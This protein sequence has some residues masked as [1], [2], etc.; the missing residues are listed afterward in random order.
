M[1][2]DL[3]GG[4]REGGKAGRAGDEFAREERR[5]GG[6]RFASFR[7]ENGYSGKGL[8]AAVARHPRLGTDC[9]WARGPGIAR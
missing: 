6:R 5:S 4:R 9:V 3:Q 8:A 7:V 1:V 2:T